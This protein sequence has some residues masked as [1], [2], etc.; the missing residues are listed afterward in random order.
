MID[1]AERLTDEQLAALERRIAR[2]YR[3][4]RNALEAQAQAYFEQFA[5]RDEEMRAMLEDGKI[6]SEEYR[7]WRLTQIARGHRFTELRDKCAERLVHANE[8]A[9][10]YVNDVT[11]S[12][13]SLGHNF[14]AFELE[15]LGHDL[16]I[17]TSFTLWNERTVRRL[18]VEVPDL[19]PPARIDIPKDLLWNREKI[20]NEITAAIIRGE[21]IPKIAARVQAVTDANEVSAR[22]TART[23]L[24]NA[25][26]AGRQDTYTAAVKMGINV[27]KRW[28]SAKDNR[29]RH[30]HG[31]LDGQTVPIDQPFISPLGSRMMPPGD[32]SLGALGKVIYNCRCAMRTVEKDGIEAEPRM[33]RVRNPNTGRNEVIEAATYT[34]WMKAQGRD[35]YGN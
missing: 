18:I 16:D 9:A 11:P 12:L 23:A 8:V 30:S 31:A 28:V 21:G 15:N 2:I 22:R 3:D 4:A 33:M 1:E 32:L 27:K 13:V 10:S 24:T 19:L 7:D 5:K 20:T 17:G 14:A 29:V 6:T 25:Q 34:E 35:A 26:N